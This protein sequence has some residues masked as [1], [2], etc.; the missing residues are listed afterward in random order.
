[1]K[2]QPRVFLIRINVSSAVN[3]APTSQILPVE[4]KGKYRNT[5]NKGDVT[6]LW[7]MNKGGLGYVTN[8]RS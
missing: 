3:D 4:G 7:S 6:E 5:H 2:V 1:M 8:C